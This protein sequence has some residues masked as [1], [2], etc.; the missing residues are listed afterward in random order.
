[1][2]LLDELQAKRRYTL[3]EDHITRG[4]RK[5]RSAVEMRDKPHSIRTL[6]HRRNYVNGLR[7]ER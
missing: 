3:T 1:M 4:Q 2:L 5:V 7:L 6:G